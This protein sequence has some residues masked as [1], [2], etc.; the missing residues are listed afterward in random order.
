MS[1]CL[2]GQIQRVIGNEITS[3]W[4]PVSSVFSQGFI[5]GSVLFNIFVND[6]NVGLECMLSKLADDTGFRGTVD[7]I[8]GREALQG[9]LDKLECWTI[10]TCT[11]FDNSKC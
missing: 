11:K 2:T 10:A 4:K 7:F 1:N 8:K 6:L 9:D 3:C 5:L